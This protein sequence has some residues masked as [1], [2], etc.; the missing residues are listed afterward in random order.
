[1]KNL[2]ESRIVTQ[3]VKERIYIEEGKKERIGSAFLKQAI[4]IL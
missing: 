4:E 2:L 1:M 3:K